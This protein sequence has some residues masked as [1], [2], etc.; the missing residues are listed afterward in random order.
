MFSARGGGGGLV[1]PMTHI[2]HTNRR[3]Y[4]RVTSCQLLARLFCQPKMRHFFGRHGGKGVFVC[5]RTK[6][7]VAA[8]NDKNFDV[9]LTTED[10]LSVFMCM[11]KLKISIERI[12]NRKIKV[13]YV[14]GPF[15]SFMHKY[16]KIAAVSPA[17]QIFSWP[18]LKSYAAE[19]LPVHFH[20]KRKL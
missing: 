8:V 20:T 18:F 12:K 19:K 7:A 17:I 10:N 1:F 6:V 9:I 11:K 4:K 14:L 2:S 13:L 3:A 15:Q 16:P 5:P